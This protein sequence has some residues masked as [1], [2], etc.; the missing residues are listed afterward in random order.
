MI[1]RTPY[2]Y[3]MH[4]ASKQSGLECKDKSMT[5]QS[6]KH[7]ASIQNIV[8]KYLKTGL[9]T[10]HQT[11][12]LPEEF[13]NI[14]DFHTAM[15]M[16][17]RGEESFNSLPAHLRSEYGNDVGRFMAALSDPTQKQKLTDL[18]VFA[19]SQEATE[20]PPVQS[21]EVPAQ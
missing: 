6:Y 17:K 19:A 3:D 12:P 1:P 2:N 7:Q 11:P 4:Q 5:Q 8:N 10:G 18:G 16:V 20:P 9:V 15:N 21:S 14:T 13:V